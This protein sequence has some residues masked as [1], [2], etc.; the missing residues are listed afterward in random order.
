M[1]YVIL[2]TETTDLKGDVVQMAIIVLD[3]NFKVESFDSFY[4]NTDKIVSEG[5]FK[6]HGISNQ[7]AKELSEGK[8]LE[9]YL[10]GNP[11]YKK[12]L[13]EPGVVFVGFNVMFDLNTINRVLMDKTGVSFSS[14]IKCNSILNLDE[15]RRYCLDMM[16]YARRKTGM[17]KG[18]NLSKAVELIVE[19]VKGNELEDLYKQV[20]KYYNVK[21]SSHSFHDA[22]YDTYCTMLL[23]FQYGKEV[24]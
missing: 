10:L 21:H 8:F 20:S 24:C 12:L 13:F 2:D 3:D 23:L 9:D 6:V 14:P 5:A 15:K 11:K 1:K 4:C 18:L 17:I 7:M 16:Y 19:D 22:A